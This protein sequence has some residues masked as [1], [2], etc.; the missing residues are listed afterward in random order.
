M[1]QIYAWRWI[2]EQLSGSLELP[3]DVMMDLPKVIITGG[4]QLQIENHKGILEYTP[5]RIRVATAQGEVVVSG[6]RLRISN[7]MPQEVAVGGHIENVN[8]IS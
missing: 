1:R 7:I 4:V 3:Q 8:I 6:T 5:R 2:K